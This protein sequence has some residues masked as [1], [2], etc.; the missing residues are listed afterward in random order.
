MWRLSGELVVNC[1]VTAGLASHW[2]RVTEASRP[3]TGRWEPAYS[4]LVEYGVTLSYLRH[5]QCLLYETRD[6]GWAQGSFVEAEAEVKTE[7]SRQSRGRGKTAWSRGEAEPVKKLP[8]G[9]LESR[10]MPRGLKRWNTV[11]YVHWL[12]ARAPNDII[13]RANSAMSSGAVT[14]M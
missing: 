1:Q 6:Q 10:Q 12:P 7:R 8:R 4:L 3:R 5:W 2:P 13:I 9:R 14:V 11:R